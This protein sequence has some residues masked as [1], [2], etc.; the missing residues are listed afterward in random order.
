MA[1]SPFELLSI[2]DGAY[3]EDGESILLRLKTDK[4][5]VVLN[6]RTDRAQDSARKIAELTEYAIASA[7]KTK[8]HRLVQAQVVA[9]AEASPAIDSTKVLLSLR[10]TTGIVHT[11]SLT[12]D[13]AS[14]LVPAL[15]KALAEATRT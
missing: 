1:T 14:D 7:G 3:T 13:Q 4:G 8:S 12:P 2:L 9:T 11:Y 10:V 5:I 15:T 6:A